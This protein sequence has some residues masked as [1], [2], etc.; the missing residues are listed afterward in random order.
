MV[1]LG[2]LVAFLVL[3]ATLHGHGSTYNALHGV[4]IVI[5]VGLL[6]AS[7]ALRG[8]GRGRIGSR[9]PGSGG[10]SF[11]TGPPRTN[12]PP[13]NPDPEAGDQPGADYSAR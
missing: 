1:R 11:G 4:Y 9:G 13:D 5:I 2:V 10:G 7:F 12:L 8:R 6:I 3:A